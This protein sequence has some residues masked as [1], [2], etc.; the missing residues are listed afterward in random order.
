M[1]W[2]SDR[3]L[4]FLGELSL[5]L[6]MLLITS[7]SPVTNLVLGKLLIIG[8]PSEGIA[9]AFQPIWAPP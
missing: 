6:M 1:E 4:E 2:M 7:T 5:T 8:Q 9:M 3:F